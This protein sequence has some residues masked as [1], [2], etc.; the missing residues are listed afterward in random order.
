MDAGTVIVK[1]TDVL[2]VGEGEGGG[3]R[4]KGTVVLRVELEAFA[5][6]SLGGDGVASSAAIIVY[7]S[8]SITSVSLDGSASVFGIGFTGSKSSKYE[9]DSALSIR[10]ESLGMFGLMR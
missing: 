2:D 6:S 4:E 5:L 10:L 1:L 9:F 8:C 7:G 3:A